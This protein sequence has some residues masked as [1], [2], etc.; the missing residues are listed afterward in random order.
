LNEVV[1]SE[2][3][4]KINL[5]M[6][7]STFRHKTGKE[8]GKY[9]VLSVDEASKSIIALDRENGY[10]AVRIPFVASQTSEGLIVNV[11]Y[12]NMSDMALGAVDKTEAV[13]NATQEIEMISTDV[14]EYNV[15]VYTNTK[16]N[17]LTIKLEE[18]TGLLEAANGKI[19]DLEGH[20]SVFQTE[21]EQ[22]NAEK[23]KGIIDALIASR[24]TE[25]GAYSEFLEYCIEIDYSK[26]VETIESEIKD[27]HYNFMA[28][29]Q[30]GGKKNFSAIEVPV[31]HNLGDE[32]TAIVER[33]G[34]EIASELKNFK[35]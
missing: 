14:S 18:T 5:L 27:I 33:Y 28:K 22:Y 20:L 15:S 9:I 8:Y 21:R 6:A 34:S 13:F 3:C 26:T 7:E 11:D 32:D 29:N 23:H 17:D 16:I 10:A 19:A 1:F 24:R 12:S 35:K 30:A 31:V 25:M 4:A 2:V